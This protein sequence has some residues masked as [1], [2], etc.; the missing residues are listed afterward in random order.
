MLFAI[1]ISNVPFKSRIFRM[2][3]IKSLIHGNAAVSRA[4]S[5]GKLAAA[6]CGVTPSS[7]LALCSFQLLN[8]LNVAS[9][10]P[11]NLLCISDYFSQVAACRTPPCL[12]RIKQ[13][14]V[15]PP[16]VL[17][18]WAPLLAPWSRGGA[19]AGPLP[20]SL[21]GPCAPGRLPDRRSGPS[22]DGG[23]GLAEAGGCGVLMSQAA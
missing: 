19:D 22:G 5:M 17:R 4:R 8:I 18:S 20:A 21:W 7:I 6:H 12:L 13:I 2:N 16:W 11:L 10:S 14:Q 3:L 15:G 1:S 9:R 23:L